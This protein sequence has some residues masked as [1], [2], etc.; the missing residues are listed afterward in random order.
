MDAKT[1]ERIFEPFFTTKEAGKGTSLGLSTVCGVVK[2]HGGFLHV[3]SEP[4]RAAC[5][6]SI[7]LRC[8]AEA[9]V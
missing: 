7:F 4:G 9:A 1:L 6:G 3:Y 5:S 2:Q 8:L